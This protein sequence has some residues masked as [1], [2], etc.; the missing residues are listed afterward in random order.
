MSLFIGIRQAPYSDNFIVCVDGRLSTHI[1]N[2][3][4]CATDNIKKYVIH[5]D[6]LIIT[7]GVDVAMGKFQAYCKK[8][9]NVNTEKIFDMVINE[10]QPYINKHESL[11]WFLGIYEL[12]IDKQRMFNLFCDNQGNISKTYHSITT[13][14]FLSG[15][16]SEEVNNFI[17]TE[18]A[19]KYTGMADIIRNILNFANTE[20]VGGTWTIFLLTPNNVKQLAAYHSPE[21][22]IRRIQDVH[23]MITSSNIIGSHFFNDGQ[24]TKLTLGMNG[25]LGDMT[26]TRT[27]D[28]TKVFQV[29]DDATNT[30]FKR[31]DVGF[32]YTG[33]KNTYMLGDWYY[34]NKPL[35]TY[36]QCQK[37]EQKLTELEERI[38]ELENKI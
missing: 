18:I 12:Q 36:E 28:G 3:A 2:V 1:N 21:I 10:L 30:T 27:S 8:Y 20:E 14:T 29:Y 7:F 23:G 19:G 24:T 4:Y 25:N 38:S 5:N 16:L 32:L 6:K 31:D 26:L 22:N 37:L 35:P 17:N 11:A 15:I 9:P 13:D 33:G 34:N